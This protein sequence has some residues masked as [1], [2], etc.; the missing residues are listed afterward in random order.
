[1]CSAAVTTFALRRVGDDDAPAV[2]ASTST[3]VDADA[4]PGD[5]DEP[6]AALDDG[7]P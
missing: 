6:L 4:G 2:A 1:V 5:H 7:P 3:I